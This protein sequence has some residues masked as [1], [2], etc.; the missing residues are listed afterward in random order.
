MGA[1]DK[2]KPVL[3]HNGTMR[4]VLA[5]ALGDGV[6]AAK[7]L[8]EGVPAGYL[9]ELVRELELSGEDLRAVFGLPRA[10][11][12]RRR[13]EGV[14][15]PREAELVYRVARLWGLARSVFEGD[16]AA[17]RCWMKTPHPELGGRA[18]LF[19]A[20][21]EPAAREAEALLVRALSGVGV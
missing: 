8:E 9:E 17:A 10:T 1:L 18:P 3:F 5:W 7:K 19:A 12:F 21:L 11:W 16:E 2:L 4:R 20:R 13:R 15:R 6:E 14:L